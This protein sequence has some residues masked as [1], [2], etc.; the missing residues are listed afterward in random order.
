MSQN[1]LGLTKFLRA[2]DLEKL[3]STK[4]FP[5]CFQQREDKA[6]PSNEHPKK[7]LRTCLTSTQYVRVLSNNW[8]T[9]RLLVTATIFSEG[10]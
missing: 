4:F 6:D 1:L 8:N 7:H 9:Y 3:N 5:N 10:C 2:G